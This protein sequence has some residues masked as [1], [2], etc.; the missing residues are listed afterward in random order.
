MNLVPERK[1]SLRRKITLRSIE[2]R[3]QGSEGESSDELAGCRSGAEQG[4][5]KDSG[6]RGDLFDLYR[7][8]DVT[9]RSHLCHSLLGETKTLDLL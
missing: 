7:E 6:E 8:T 1:Q 5:E 3:G 2:R 9:L 4:V